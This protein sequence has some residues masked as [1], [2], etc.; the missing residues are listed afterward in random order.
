MSQARVTNLDV[1]R[2]VRGAL[3]TFASDVNLALSEV[4][5]DAQ[6]LAHWLR[7]EAPMYWQRQVRE[8]QELLTRAKSDL[9][10]KQIAPVGDITP[11]ATDEKVNLARAKSRLEEAER[12]LAAVKRWAN[13]VEHEYVLYKAAAQPI[14]DLVGREVPVAVAQLDRMA[15]A[16]EGYTQIAPPPSA[17]TTPAEPTE[18]SA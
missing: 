12:K 6:K 7:T 11:G 5:S 14:S 15:T 10:R 3:I 17:E 4:D 2:E 16:L 1:L 8:R 13:V 18:P 9:Y